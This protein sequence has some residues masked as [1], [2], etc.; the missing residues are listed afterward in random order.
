MVTAIGVAGA[1]GGEEELVVEAAVEEALVGGALELLLETSA[2]E[3]LCREVGSCREV[4]SCGEL[5]VERTDVA[6]APVLR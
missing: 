4:E 3:E 5:G 1:D 2:A 6:P